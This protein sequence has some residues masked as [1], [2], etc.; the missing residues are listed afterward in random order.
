M[1]PNCLNNKRTSE[2]IIIP[3][4]KLDYMAIVI[5]TAW[6]WYRQRHIDQ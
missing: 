5:K 4:L 3:D 2:G 6:Y 1:G